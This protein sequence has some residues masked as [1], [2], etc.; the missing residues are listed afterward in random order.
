MLDAVPETTKSLAKLIQPIKSV[1]AMNGVPFGS[2]P[3]ITGSTKY[4][5]NLKISEG[6][7]T[8]FRI[9][10]RKLDAQKSLA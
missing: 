10:L 5:P 6:V 7:K 8:S 3:A 4:G 9:K 1:D 2:K